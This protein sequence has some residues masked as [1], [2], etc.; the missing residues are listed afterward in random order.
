MAKI[1]TSDPYPRVQLVDTSSDKVCIIIVCLFVYS[2]PLV[3]DIDVAEQLVATGHAQWVRSHPP[4]PYTLSS[5]GNHPLLSVPNCVPLTDQSEVSVSFVQS[6][7][8]LFVIPTGYELLLSQLCERMNT[9]F[10]QSNES[11]SSIKI[12]DMVAANTP[13]NKQWYRGHVISFNKSDLSAV[14]RLVDYGVL[15]HL[16]LSQLRPLR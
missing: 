2:A 5:H 6:P 13:L 12:G 7:D 10:D 14:V 4:Y 15:F 1:T 3:Q 11:L 9:L 8:L 16:P